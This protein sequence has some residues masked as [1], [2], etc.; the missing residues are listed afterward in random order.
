MTCPAHGARG[1]TAR[2]YLEQTSSVWALAIGCIFALYLRWLPV[3]REFESKDFQTFTSH[4]YEAV[5][6]S[7]LAAAG[8]DVANYTPTYLY[9]L[10][11]VVS[12]FPG[13]PNVVGVKIPSLVAD[14]VC[15][16]FVFLITRLQHPR[17]KLPYC[18]FVAVLLL[19]S[20]VANGAIWGQADSIYTSMLLACIYC[21]MTGRPVLAMVA[22][23]VAFSFKIQTVF[24]APAIFVLLVNRKIPWWAP[25]IVPATYV[26]MMLPAWHE[27][28]PFKDLLLVY[29]AQGQGL[30][31]LNV[32]APNL[33]MWFPWTWLE[34][35][36]TEGV[37]AGVALTGALVLLLAWRVWRSRVSLD[38]TLTLRICML[39]L[40]MTPYFLPKMHERYFFAADVLAI[41]Y[42]FFFPRQYFVPV[43]IGFASFMVYSAH[44]FEIKFVPFRVLSLTMF[45]ALVAIAWSTLRALNPP[46]SPA[47]REGSP[48]LA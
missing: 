35:F 10:N 36:Y 17:G 27:G 28:R 3:I 8:T 25:L 13:L 34:R 33:Y 44:L 48:G 18:A 5:R 30:S 9:L 15:A 14:V 42:A 12:L 24:L 29:V 47:A 31:K 19:P 41:A 6:I 11:V 2:H 26:L 1:G 20:V 4:W 21:L 37:I 7:G 38:A 22:F 43:F 32:Q 45:A 16:A 46:P 40:V 39:S 23:G